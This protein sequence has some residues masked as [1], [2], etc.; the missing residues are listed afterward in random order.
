MNTGL[1]GQWKDCTTYDQRDTERKPTTYAVQHGPL[2]IVVTC[3]HIYYR[4]NWVMHCFNIGIDTKP[5]KA[6]TLTDAKV[7]SIQL[8]G[9][10]IK[11]LHHSYEMI[12]EDSL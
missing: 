7:E 8:V 10:L 11:V 2:R 1:I 3:G 5:L 4:P 6:K 9:A 12:Y